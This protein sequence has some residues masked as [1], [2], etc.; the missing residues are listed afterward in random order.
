VHDWIPS[1]CMLQFVLNSFCLQQ[2][3]EFPRRQYGISAC[4]FQA[5]S[6]QHHSTTDDQSDRDIECIVCKGERKFKE[7]SVAAI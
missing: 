7:Y 1:S 2:I 6:R 5:L 3:A 4:S